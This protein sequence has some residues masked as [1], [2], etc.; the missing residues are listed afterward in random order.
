MFKE[1]ITKSATE[2]T[3][4]LFDQALLSVVIKDEKKIQEQYDSPIGFKQPWGSQFLLKG[5]QEE[6][7]ERVLL[8]L[9]KSSEL[10]GFHSFY[11]QLY[12]NGDAAQVLSSFD[13]GD[14]GASV[15]LWKSTDSL[16]LCGN[17]HFK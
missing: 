15:V 13:Y 5:N 14:G 12:G 16:Y 7:R 6:L 11:V 2:A 9:K 8:N 4:L 17:I 10:P 3:N 1:I